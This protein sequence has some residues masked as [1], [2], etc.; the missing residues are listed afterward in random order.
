MG[1]QVQVQV[2][3]NQERVVE[4]KWVTPVSAEWLSTVS[5]RFMRKQH[6]PCN[7][8][9]MMHKTRDGLKHKQAG[10]KQANSIDRL[11]I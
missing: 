7:I 8:I 5:M 6:S 11:I 3:R 2:Y 10:K 4:Y 9:L 1:V